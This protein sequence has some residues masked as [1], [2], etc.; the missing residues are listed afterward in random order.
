MIR[1]V[2]ASPRL[3][4]MITTYNRD[5]STILNQVNISSLVDGYAAS[6]SCGQQVIYKIRTWSCNPRLRFSPHSIRN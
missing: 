2:N 6:S 1:K 3:D 5:K 4:S